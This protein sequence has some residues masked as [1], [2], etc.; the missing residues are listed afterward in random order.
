MIEVKNISYSYGRQ[1]VLKDI[2]FSVQTGDC[3]GILGNNGAGKSTLVTCI[4]R[5]RKS[6]SGSVYIDGRN[7]FSMGRLEAA[8]NIAYVAQKNEMSQT[9][10]YDA[11][12]LGRKP[13][14]KW[15]LTGEDYTL[16]DEMIE[17]VGMTGF[18]L[19]YINELSGG[20]AQKVILARAFVQ[21]PKLLLLDEPTS[22]L[23][24]KNQYEMMKLVRSMAEERNIA[25]L[26]V[27]HD[28]N[29][30]L[31]YCN[32]FLFVKDGLVYHFGDESVVTEQ[33][34]YDVYGIRASMVLHNDRKYAII[35]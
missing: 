4:N 16:C 25:V 6:D 10:V 14:M 2:S 17:K 29:L 12:L 1:R 3:V 22:N 11:V 5:I 31:R 7:I 19:R 20:E 32:R 26:V 18:K 33:A 35:E 15:G 34:L 30:A 24:P 28:L 23:D 21:Q 8:R 13:Y 27:I 9:T